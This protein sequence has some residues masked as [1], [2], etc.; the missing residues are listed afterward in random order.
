MYAH[1][2]P[3]HTAP[4][5][6]A[7]HRTAPHRTAP[8]HTGCERYPPWHQ[9]ANSTTRATAA[10]AQQPKH[11]QQAGCV[12]QSSSR[13]QRTP[14]HTHS[15]PRPQRQSFIQCRHD[16]S[17]GRRKAAEPTSRPTGPAPHAAPSPPALT[18]APHAAAGPLAAPPTPL[19]QRPAAQHA[20]ARCC[21]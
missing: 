10:R 20:T 6:T 19:S 9:T 14:T 8:H 21:R 1:A 7:P 16:S 4:H 17:S 2:R 3:H 13:L 18:A 5:R 15:Q 11:V 12:S